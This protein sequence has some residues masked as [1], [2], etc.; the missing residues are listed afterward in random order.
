MEG[1]GRVCAQATHAACVMREGL[2][3]ACHL[4][5][6]CLRGPGLDLTTE[7]REGREAF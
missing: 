3:L 4:C 7:I 6:A 2:C 5:L 1:G